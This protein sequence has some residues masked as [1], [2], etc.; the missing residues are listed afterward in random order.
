MGN[1]I[2]ENY[3]ALW[4]E[5]P[6]EVN[7]I[8]VYPIH[9]RDYAEW[10][11]C[12]RVLTIRQSTLPAA[13]AVMPYLS[14]L[15]AM[16]ADMQ[17]GLMYQVVKVLALATRQNPMD[18]YA[19]CKEED[20]RILNAI[21][22]RASDIIFR[23][24]AS[25]FP[26]FREVIARQNGLELPDEAENPE[27]VE[28]EHDL[29]ELKAPKLDY[30]M[31]ALVMSVAYQ[32]RMR[33]KELAEWTVREFEAAREAINRDK[34]FTRFGSGFYSFKNNENPYPSWCFER[35]REGSSALEPLSAFTQRTG[36]GG[37][38]MPIKQG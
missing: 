21:V 14:A 8:Y 29:N 9:M 22:C 4:N 17:I 16:D 32:Y 15:H 34:Y 2:S 1:G 25:Q 31:N 36:I 3:G 35:Q 11:S 19:M 18:F 26:K 27:L 12:K 33:P 23:I 38:A 7:G 30:D 5:E 10:C 24:D 6:E 13:Y 37:N 20:Q 28:A